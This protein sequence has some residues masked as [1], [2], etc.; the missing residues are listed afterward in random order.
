MLMKRLLAISTILALSCASIS[1][2]KGPQTSLEARSICEVRNQEPFDESWQSLTTKIFPVNFGEIQNIFVNGLGLKMKE[3][4]SI[5]VSTKLIGNVI[6]DVEY[7]LYNFKLENNKTS[8]DNFPEITIIEGLPLSDKEINAQV[9]IEAVVQEKKIYSFVATQLK[10]IAQFNN[11]SILGKL[12][13]ELGTLINSQ[14]DNDEYRFTNTIKVFESTSQEKK[15][16]SILVY[17]IQT[18][19]ATISKSAAIEASL[20]KL[21]SQPNAIVS[22]TSLKS[23][24]GNDNTAYIFV[25]NYLSQYNSKLNLK[26]YTHE[27]INNR[28]ASIQ[29]TQQSSEIVSHEK[30]FSDFLHEIADLKTEVDDYRHKADEPKLISILARYKTICAIFSN[31]TKDYANDKLFNSTFKPNYSIAL[32]EAKNSLSTGDE[33]L[34]Y[35]S[36]ATQYIIGDKMPADPKQFENILDTLDNHEFQNREDHNVKR[37]YAIREHLE[38]QIYSNSFKAPVDDIYNLLSQT[39][40]SS[41]D[42]IVEISP[43][44]NCQKCKARSEEAIKYYNSGI[45]NGGSTLPPITI[46]NGG[47]GSSINFDQ[48]R[49]SFRRQENFTATSTGLQQYAGTVEQAETIHEAQTILNKFKTLL[50][51][52][53]V[54]IK[55]RHKEA[56]QTY[57]LLEACINTNDAVYSKAQLMEIKH[58]SNNLD[59]YMLNINK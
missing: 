34:T 51:K 19:G 15:I 47:N 10:N 9:N 17:S 6:N 41:Y 45:S 43:T 36:H 54:V 39:R 3:I 53:E 22:T 1:A 5:F 4:K 42:K 11:P 50:S 26:S 46:G 57:Q 49:A 32:K 58:L 16:H 8:V 7:P 14:N 48:I 21:I 37:I 25:V 59:D 38:N 24:V 31:V 27:D 13:G 30:R 40:K 23:M 18:N 29:S 2:Q 33:G 55:L 56:Y 52:N 28:L 20:R 35:V 12:V 44:T